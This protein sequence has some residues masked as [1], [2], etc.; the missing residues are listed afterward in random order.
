[1]NTKYELSDFE[2]SCDETWPGGR[3]L[4]FEGDDDDWPKFAKE[5]RANGITVYMGTFEPGEGQT[6]LAYAICRVNNWPFGS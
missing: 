2:K 4:Y 6:G 5:M 3:Y 1:M